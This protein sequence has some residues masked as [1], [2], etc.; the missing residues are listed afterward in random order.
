[1]RLRRVGPVLLVIAI[2][3]SSTV[4]QAAQSSVTGT[5]QGHLVLCAPAPMPVPGVQLIVPFTDLSAPTDADGLFTLS[6]VPAAQPVTLAVQIATGA[7]VM[8]NLPDL[9]VGANQ[10]RDIGTLGLAG[11]GDPGVIVEGP[12]PGMDSAP[13]PEMEGAP[14]PEMDAA[15]V[16]E[17]EGAPSG[18]DEPSDD[19]PTPASAD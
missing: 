15:P 13:A 19:G 3:A 14:V 12:A 9:E 8:L 7:L 1:M 10:T 18:D 17:M 2:L 16:P 11:C 6:G 4:A 5:L